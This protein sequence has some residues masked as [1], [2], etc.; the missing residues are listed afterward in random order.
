MTYPEKAA[1][2]LRVLPANACLL[3]VETSCDETAAAVL[4]GGKVLSSVISSQIASH[5]KFHGV[6]PEIASRLHEE[7]VAFVTSQALAEANKSISSLQAVAVTAGPGLVG[8]LLV[9]VSFAKA[10]AFAR[11]IPFIGVHHIEGH[12]AANYLAHPE[13]KPPFL[14]LVV[15][16]GHSHNVL[17]EDYGRYRLLGKTRDDAAGEAFDKT[18][19]ALGLSYPGGVAIEQAAKEGNERAFS[20]HT[21]VMREQGY[22]YSFSGVKTAVV[23]LVKRF[24]EQNQP[25]PV[26]DIAASFQYFVASSLA[27]KAVKAARDYGLPQVVL[28]G[29]VAANLRLRKELQ[30]RCQ[31][32]GISLYYPPLELCTDNAAMIGMAGWHRLQRGESSPLS[33][34]A[35]ASMGLF[36]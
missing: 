10:L 21:T 4:Q 23:Q 11:G 3:A 30:T 2:N 9:G 15:S 18:A 14:A 1:E 28:C 36:Y 31:Q 19:R 17:V 12:I 27:D 33:L 26:A 6:V 25:L 13:L 7:N 5:Q 22:D 20:F 35:Q 8:A 34:N 16:G 32:E 29:G 24:S